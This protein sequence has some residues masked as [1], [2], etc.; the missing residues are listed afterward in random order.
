MEEILW[1]FARNNQE[2]QDLRKDIRGVWDDD[3]ARS[4]N[5]RY[6]DPHEAAAR[7]VETALQ[8]QNVYISE[9][10]KF[11]HQALEEARRVDDFS[12]K[13]LLGLESTGREMS[14]VFSS[15]EEARNLYSM[16]QA[17]FPQ[18]D[19]YIQSANSTC[20]GVLTRD[21]YNRSYSR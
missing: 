4:I 18:I 2:L 1:R 12:H 17:L 20:E 5:S 9:A 16:G 8:K 13:A 3:A 15:H 14:L 19:H 11:R 10:R 6:L 7:E 21:E